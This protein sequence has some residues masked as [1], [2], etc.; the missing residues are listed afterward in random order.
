MIRSLWGAGRKSQ[1]GPGFPPYMRLE[2]ALLRFGRGASSRPFVLRGRPN[3]ADS[4]APACPFRRFRLRPARDFPP[5]TPPTRHVSWRRGERTPSTIQC[6][7][8]AARYHGMPYPCLGVSG[9]GRGEWPPHDYPSRQQIRPSRPDPTSLLVS[10][11]VHAAATASISTR[12]PGS[13]R[14]VMITVKAG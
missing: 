11:P 1:F 8:S 12:Q 9:W 5:Y 4:Y 3:V 2:D 7:M 6:V 10:L 14:S 13:N